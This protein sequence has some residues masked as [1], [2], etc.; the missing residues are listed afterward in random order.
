MNFNRISACGGL[1]VKG[2]P[3]GMSVA[4]TGWGCDRSQLPKGMP[5]SSHG[6]VF[7]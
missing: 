2:S 7:Y 1:I 3:R 6:P 5:K 4:V